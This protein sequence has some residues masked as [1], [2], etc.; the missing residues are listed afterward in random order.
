MRHIKHILIA[1][2]LSFTFAP[3]AAISQTFDQS[4]TETQ[5]MKQAILLGQ[6]RQFDQAFAILYATPINDRD[7]FAY[8]FTRA[9]LLCWSG[10][11]EE[12]DSLYQSLL[13]KNPAHPDVLVSQGYLELFRGEPLK[14]TARFEQVVGLYPGYADAQTGVIRAQAL[15]SDNAS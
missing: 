11:F 3:E 6:N 9:R 7:S 15:I 12:A 4:E 8:I 5:E 10:Q 13:V 2:L 14:A 1:G